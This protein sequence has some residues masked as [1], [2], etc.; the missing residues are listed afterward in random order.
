MPGTRIPVVDEKLLLLDSPDY[1]L[2]FSWHIAVPI[3]R[4]I[5]SQGFR[6]S[7]IIPLPVPK[8][9]NWREI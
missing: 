6:G 1:L 7:F 3:M 4:N 9:I 2:I 5:V 8:V